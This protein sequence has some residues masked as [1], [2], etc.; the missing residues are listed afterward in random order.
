MTCVKYLKNVSISELSSLK[1]QDL[2]EGRRW[3]HG[4]SEFGQ[5]HMEVATDIYLA[6][7]AAVK[8]S[9]NLAFV[10]AENMSKSTEFFVFLSERLSPEES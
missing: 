10:V 4:R 2:V 9:N 7:L 8:L 1:R 5:V 6:T 3:L